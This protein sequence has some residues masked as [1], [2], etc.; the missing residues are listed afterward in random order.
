MSN[1]RGIVGFDFHNVLDLHPQM[2]DLLWVFVRDEYEVHIISAVG[3]KRAGTIAGEVDKILG[4][5]AQD[6]QVH[7]VVFRHPRE[8]PILKAELA[9]L[10]GIEIFF[11]DRADVCE[12]MNHEGILCLQVPRKSVLSDIEADFQ[13]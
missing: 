12:A 4:P 5:H 3:P 2:I 6:I 1:T 10:L 9:R 7:E 8:S 13:A 11:D